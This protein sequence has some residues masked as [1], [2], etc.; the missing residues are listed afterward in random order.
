VAPSVKSDSTASANDEP[1]SSKGGDSECQLQKQLRVRRI[2]AGGTKVSA[3]EG[4]R[5]AQGEDDEANQEAECEATKQKFA[6]VEEANK[7]EFAEVKSAREAS[8]NLLKVVRER[9]MVELS[10]TIKARFHVNTSNLL[11]HL[12]W[13]KLDAPQLVRWM[14]CPGWS[15]PGG[16]RN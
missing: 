15:D 10:S 4:P 8:D 11:D 14:E 2:Q 16:L 13:C 6:E 5:R 7:L 1:T 9:V 3:A 12:D